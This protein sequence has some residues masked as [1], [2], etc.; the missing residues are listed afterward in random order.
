MPPS[1]PV[2]P[3]SLSARLAGL[4][5]RSLPSNAP[6]VIVESLTRVL[7][8]FDLHSSSQ[9]G[10][11]PHPG[12]T[13]T[14]STATPPVHSPLAQVLPQPIPTIQ[15][16]VCLN[17]K[18]TLSV[19]YT[20]EDVNAWVEYPETNSDR[21]VG[22]LFR[23][24]PD[25]WNN[26]VR[27]FSYSLGEPSGRTKRGNEVEISLLK[28]HNGR[29]VPCAVAHSTCKSNYQVLYEGMTCT[30]LL[31][32]GQ[33]SKVCPMSDQDL[34]LSSHTSASREDVNERLRKDRQHKIDTA[35]PTRDI[36]QKTTA[37]ISA[38]QILGCRGPMH[39]SRL[40]S[41]WEQEIAD[42]LAAH[43]ATI[44]RGF[45]P[46]HPLCSGRL[47]LWYGSV[48]LKPYIQYVSHCMYITS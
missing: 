32:L 1:L 14:G 24:D 39:E 28:D 26:P 6:P 42:L 30:V 21:P 35:S 25:N 4:H 13:T 11:E 43:K 46:K 31:L 20:F 27:N 38:L 48:N 33:G 36:F 47:E 12:S 9:A 2:S 15:R 41:S 5:D 10:P 23:C 44:Q 16:N 34:M 45:T 17:R 3:D 40:V 19:L 18:T 29:N 7:D 37:L 8:Y 22:Y